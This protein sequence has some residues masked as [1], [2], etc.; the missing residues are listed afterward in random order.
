MHNLFNERFFSLRRPAWHGL[1]TVSDT[2]IPA[3]QAFNQMTPFIVALEPLFLDMDGKRVESAYQA[4]T[5][6]PVPDDPEFR[7]FGVV[8]S[9]YTL[10]DPLTVCEVYDENVSTPVETM[11]ALGS[12]DTFFL[13]TKLP[14]YDIK[15]D[16]VENYMLVVSPY[17]GNEAMQVRVTSIRVVCQNTLMAAKRASV[18]TY[19]IVHKSNAVRDLR[20]WMAGV[21][22]RS[23]DRAARM[24]V[25]YQ[26]MSERP[27]VKVEVDPLLERIYPAPRPFQESPDVETTRQR[28]EWFES[29]ISAVTR[30]REAVRQIFEGA[31]LGQETPAARGTAWGLFNAV[32][33]WEQYRPTSRQSSAWSDMLVGGRA[34]TSALAYDVLAEVAESPMPKKAKARPTQVKVSLV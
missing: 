6:Y 15:G 7:V 22:F 29:N 11:G 30:H 1:G 28:Q 34:T 24:A 5:R 9:Q 19:R 8:G 32:C 18:E 20:A 14:S 23:N 2:E 21:S 31:G 16:E 17:G 4:I 26:K 27:L 3:V 33:E 10:V 13:T 25:T 12:G